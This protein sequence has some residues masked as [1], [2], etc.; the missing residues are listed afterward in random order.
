[1]L[2]NP[3][4]NE[5]LH[6]IALTYVKETGPKRAR[7]LLQHY[8]TAADIFK[9]PLKELK[10]I[11]GMGEI[12]ARAFKE[13]EVMEQ[14][15]EQLKFVLK[16]G[17]QPLWLNDDN[18]PLRLKQCADAPVLLYYRG[19]VALDMQKQV[20]IVGTRKYTDYGQKLCEDLVEGLANEENILIVS[21]LAHGIDTIAHKAAVERGLP[22]VGVLGHGLDMIYPSTNR[23]LA[24]Q[25]LEHGGL[26]SEFPSGTKPDRGNFPMRNRVVAGLCD[27]TIVVESDIKGGSLITARIADS[28]NRDVA[29][30]PG[31]VKDTKSS[32]C[33]E[34]IRTNIANMITC[35]DDLM[36]LMNWNRSKKKK[37]VQRQLFIQLS[38]EEQ[39]VIDILQ[40][41]DS[42]HADELLHQ[43]N[44]GSSILAATLLQLE[45]QG[46]VKA[47][48]GK[49]YRT[50]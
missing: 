37:P 11:D 13:P 30:F 43:S 23:T 42:V 35:A 25:M 33:N 34:L 4:T 20:A 28:Y 36:E 44:L 3:D 48:P 1:M 26:L 19:S 17:V 14:A 45:M 6:R 22:T 31:R 49:M 46:L 47:L 24:K 7:V 32:G 38:P 5:L 29:T 8:P 18:Y 39:V 2:P 21:G 15:E 27:V 40:A 12:R 9:A 10:Q 16:H 50:N 41:K